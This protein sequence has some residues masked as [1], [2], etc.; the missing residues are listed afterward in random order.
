[1][2]R[3]VLHPGFHKTGTSTLQ[4]TLRTNRDA[5]AGYA[6]ILLTPDIRPLADAARTW[7]R[8]RTAADLDAVARATTEVMDSHA[9]THGGGDLPLL[10]SSEDLCGHMP[11]RYDLRSY[12]AAPTL[13]ATINAA[14]RKTAPDADIRFHFST[15]AAQPWL[16]S[17]HMQH[18][19]YSRMELSVVR[20]SRVY[21]ASADLDG[22][23]DKVA[24]ALPDARVERKALEDC[25]GRLGPL[26]P[27][28][29]LIDVPYKH[30]RTLEKLPPQNVSMPPELRRALVELN[31]SELSKEELRAAKETLFAAH[32]QGTLS[33]A[34][35]PE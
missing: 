20:Y 11:G 25:T 32:N 23:V 30:R 26:G 3:I 21:A 9:K 15:R 6:T 8:S 33:D 34:D 17:C 7:S 13:M 10:I 29:D 14:L 16:A 24:A 18:V 22:V 31:R 2:A 19:R 28:L 1:M 5:L 35:A 4:R 12:D 27:I